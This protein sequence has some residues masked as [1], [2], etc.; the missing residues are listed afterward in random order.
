MHA[1]ETRL[2]RG[3]HASANQTGRVDKR[4]PA[5]SHF[6]FTEYAPIPPTVYGMGA[7]SGTGRTLALMAFLLMGASFVLQL[8]N[9]I[10]VPYIKKLGM[11]ELKFQ[12]PPLQRWNVHETQFGIWGWSA[13][14]G[15]DKQEVSSDAGLNNY[16]EFVG[17]L[18]DSYERSG[19]TIQNPFLKDLPYALVL[20]PISAGF[21]GLAAGAALLAVYVNSFLWVLAALWA[22]ALSAAAMVIELVLFI[23]ARQRFND[24]L[25]PLFTDE[26]YYS[27]NM[28]KGIW[29]QVA[30]L[31]AVLVGAWLMILSYIVNSIANKRSRPAVHSA[32]HTT[33][34]PVPVV[35]KDPYSYGA[36]HEPYG[37]NQGY[38]ANAYDV[39]YPN[40]AG[41]GAYANGYGGVAY[42]GAEPYEAKRLSSRYAGMPRMDAQRAS[43]Q[44]TTPKRHSLATS[45]PAVDESRHHKHKRKHHHKRH[46]SR[47]GHADRARDDAYLDGADDDERRTRSRSAP[48][49]NYEYDYDFD[50]FPSRRIS[51]EYGAPQH[52]HHHS[53]SLDNRHTRPRKPPVRMGQ[54]N[55]SLYPDDSSAVDYDILARSRVRD[56]ARWKR[57]SAGFEY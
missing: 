10:S 36:H 53:T 12:D 7:V 46:H 45:A 33:M 35:D 6:F 22:L 29:L 23:K 44:P 37:Y 14:T 40:S 4:A 3:G 50:V 54:R 18:R 57:S 48:R 2:I 52:V 51:Y 42:D 30:A 31:A 25:R 11:L 43:M 41:V 24:L 34:A 21:T 49:H 15:P 47:S 16:G 13:V 17:Q 55:S 20:Q 5:A 8:V 19:S 38:G 28:G 26:N 9:S 32:D 27:V 39:P 56:D 1:S